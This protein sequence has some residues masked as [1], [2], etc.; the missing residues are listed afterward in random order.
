M[1]G[2]DRAGGQILGR[3]RPRAGQWGKRDRMGGGDSVGYFSGTA[4]DRRLRASTGGWIIN[5]GGA[6]LA[7]KHCVTATVLR[8]HGWISNV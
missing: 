6:F 1:R 3:L 5:T 7:L 4:S 2:Y 8:V